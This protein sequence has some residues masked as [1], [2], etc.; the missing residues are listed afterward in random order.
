MFRLAY[1]IDGIPDTVEFDTEPSLNP[2]TTLTDL[3]LAKWTGFI[4][5]P[6]DVW[7]DEYVWIVESVISSM[8]AERNGI[9]HNIMHTGNLAFTLL[10]SLTLAN[11]A[12]GMTDFEFYPLLGRLRVLD[13]TNIRLEKSFEMVS[14]KGTK[15][16]HL[17]L[18]N[19]QAVEPLYALFAE[20]TACQSLTLEDMS[21]IP[22]T[23]P[24]NI[25]VLNIHGCQLHKLNV[26]RNTRVL[27]VAHNNIQDVDFLVP[28]VKYLTALNLDSNNICAAGLGKLLKVQSTL[29][30]ISA[31]N[32]LIGRE[33]DIHSILHDLEHNSTLLKLDLGPLRE[34]P[35]LANRLHANSMLPESEE[36]KKAGIT[37][38]ARKNGEFD[39]NFG[40]FSVAGFFSSVFHHKSL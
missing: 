28:C 21:M 36:A 34:H 23:F 8:P 7:S 25:S 12:V 27:N 40:L 2:G 24:P 32:M 20:F 19:V 35:L 30:S 17:R 33:H 1:T 31:R 5:E 15:I 3:Q 14:F 16:T 6:V 22:V 37:I 10:D 13:L 38:V 29:T 39:V 11:T 26:S 9:F 4:F 18:S